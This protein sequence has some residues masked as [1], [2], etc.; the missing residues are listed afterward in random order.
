MKKLHTWCL[1]SLFFCIGSLSAQNFN[2][3][4]I[5]PYL[6]DS[7]SVYLR[8][9]SALHNFNPNGGADPLNTLVPTFAYNQI[10]NTSMTCLGPSI[11]WRYGHQVHTEVTNNLGDTTTTHWHGAHVPVHTDGGPHQPIAPGATWS[12]DFEI[13][14]K[15]STMWY[16]PHAMG[17]TYEQVQTGLSGMI[18]VEDPTDGTDDPILTAIHDT[19]PHTYGVD[20]FPLIVQ[21]KFFDIDSIGNVTIKGGCCGPPGTAGYKSGYEYIINGSMNPYL[22][23]PANMIRVRILNGDGKFTFN[24]GIGDLNFNPET[25]QYIATNAGYT[26][27]TY[28]MQQVYV[29]PGD[30]TEWLIDLRGRTPGD[31]LYLINFADD[32]PSG[33]GIIGNG[34][35]TQSYAVNKAILKFIIQPNTLAPSPIA[36]FPI[37]LHPLE[38]PAYYSYTKRRNKAFT[39]TGPYLI[40]NTPMDMMVVNDTI[41]LDSTEIW[42]ITNNTT[43]AHPWH[44]HDIHFYVTEVLDGTGTPLNK[45]LY[46]QIFSGPLDVVLIEP[47]WTLSYVANFSDFGTAI[48]PDSSY[49]YH[50]HILP[51]E[52]K[53]MMGQFVVWDGSLGVSVDKI[54]AVENPLKLFPNP[55]SNELFLEGES[56]EDSRIHIFDLQGRLLK[57][58]QLSAFSGTV[59]I[60][61]EG[62][63]YGLILVEWTTTKGKFVNK[64]LIN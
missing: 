16:H 56:E 8:V 10:G 32:I 35:T 19:L 25:F 58:Q 61:I 17:T 1:I 45:S 62:L 60:S 22:E 7:D 26:D 30:R 24:L 63:S 55:T 54:N 36:T 51:H 44:I 3:P 39:G 21:T 5:I 64:V 23:V 42:T 2:N 46:P 18:Y 43:K 20:D 52:D 29:S 4:L 27:T 31:T 38:I 9:D 40:N 11:A 57:T 28:A 53:G 14:D 59:S 33:S 37:G 13:K 50:C 34:A 41:M 6:I 12:I 49:M 15:S 47:G 48:A